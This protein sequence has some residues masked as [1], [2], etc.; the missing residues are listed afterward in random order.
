MR[1]GQ[2]ELYKIIEISKKYPVIG[3]QRLLGV[4]LPFYQQYAISKAWNTKYPIFLMSRRTGKTFSS[5][6][7][8]VLKCLLFPKTKVG[9][10]ASVFRQAQTV[11]IEAE[12]L[13]KQSPF[14]QSQIIDE[15]KRGSSEWHIDWKN[16]SIFSCLPFSDNIR[17]KGFNVMDKRSHN[18]V[19]CWNI[20]KS[21]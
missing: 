6:L 15:P 12:N 7:I 16:G 14:L 18:S 2:K 9:V 21:Y 17:S 3:A 8:L 5:A 10:V 11:F 20:L 1:E 19:N 13:I 4:N